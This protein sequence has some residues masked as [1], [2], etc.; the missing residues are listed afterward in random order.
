[1][2]NA[3]SG[4]LTQYAQRLVERDAL[5]AELG[6][7][8]EKF[9]ALTAQAAD[10]VD[11]FA[12]TL[13]QIEANLIDSQLRGDKAGELSTLRYAAQVRQQQ[14]DIAKG[15]PG[16]EDDISAGSALQQ[17]LGAL[18]S[19]ETSLKED[20]AAKL[21]QALD[22]EKE[23]TAQL[24]RDKAI[25]SANSQVITHALAEIVNGR[26][27]VNLGLGGSQLRSAPGQVGSL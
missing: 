3:R 21:Q 17:V 9:K 16:L 6:V 10:P 12:G 23:K 18:E 4:T 13:Q 8:S 27:G 5:T 20:V 26:L 11:P 25:V 14:Y 19:L 7:L 22:L 15:T 1:L 24:T 2:I